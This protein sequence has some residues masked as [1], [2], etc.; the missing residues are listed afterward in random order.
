MYSR[1]NVPGIFSRSDNW[2]EYRVLADPPERREGGG[3]KRYA[4]IELDGKP[5]AYAIYRHRPGW[6]QGS[7]VAKLEVL[8]ALGATPQATAEI[9]R[10]LLDV[11]WTAHITAWLLPID[12]PLFF[13]LATPRRMRYRAG[14]GL[15]VR[16]V[17]VGAALSARRY[18]ADGRVV[19][20][21]A[22][23]FAEWNDGRWKLEGGECTS[24]N[25]DPDLRLDVTALGSVYLGGFTFAQLQSAFRVEELR[26]G[27]IAE[28]DAMFRS[29]H[30]PWCP[31]IF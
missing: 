27:A 1:A 20:E 9:W 8:E 4:V 11:D 28:A 17:D 15:W 2:W 16:L 26:T 3:P 21:V 19:F 14:D 12:H 24:T 10:Y 22:D 18:A 31:E 30:A 6:E 5:D 13:L 25:D 7:S 29:T 23:A